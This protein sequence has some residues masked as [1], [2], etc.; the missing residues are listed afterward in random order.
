[1]IGCF[2][3]LVFF[4]KVA[5]RWTPDTPHIFTLIKFAD[6]W[7]KYYSHSVRGKE[8]A[9]SDEQSLLGKYQE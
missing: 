5:P 4:P 6:Y 1:M 7:Y 2:Q 8:V 9:H 3:A